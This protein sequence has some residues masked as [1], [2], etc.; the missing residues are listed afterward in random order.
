MA[1]KKGFS[2]TKFPNNDRINA[3]VKEQFTGPYL[4][5]GIT[6]KAKAKARARKQIL[7]S[8]PEEL[9]EELGLNP[10]QKLFVDE[11]L[12]DLNAAQAAMRAGYSPDNAGFQGHCL[13]TNPKIKLAISIAKAKRARRVGITQD[14]VIQE[15]AKIAFLNPID[16][17]NPSNVTLKSKASRDDT[18]AIS[19]LRVKRFLTKGGNGV[20]REVKMY[21]K[22]RALE[23]LGK[24][25]GIFND[26]LSINA[27]MMVKIIDDI[28]DSDDSGTES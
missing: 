24:H 13:I 4:K 6:E 5:K 28:G 25:M 19:S 26:K 9:F 14:R 15:L 23:L 20:E 11:Y 22:I 27:E 3:I 1:T 7:P 10:M 16:M 8:P 12:I 18:A 21:D 2:R 17:I